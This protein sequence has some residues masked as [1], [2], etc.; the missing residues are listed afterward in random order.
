[1]LAGLGPLILLWLAGQGGQGGSRARGPEPSWPGPQHPPPASPH[2]S[3]RAQRQPGAPLPPPAPSPPPSPA[4]IPSEAPA[5]RYAAVSVL[6]VQQAVN[7]AGVKPPL[8][9]DGLYGPKTV[10]AW[11]SLAR[12]RGLDDSIVRLGP[13]T[14]DVSRPTYERLSAR[15]VSGDGELYI[16]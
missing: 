2:G 11:R 5:G 3:R 1:M 4:P 12:A 16:P 10:S 9:Q 15:G 8:K 13:K 6:S 14:V 7:R